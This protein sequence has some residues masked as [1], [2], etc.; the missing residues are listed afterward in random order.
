MNVIIMLVSTRNSTV[1]F[2]GIHANSTV[3][4]RKRDMLERHYS[5]QGT[6]TLFFCKIH[7]FDFL[8]SSEGI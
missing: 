7:L 3:S 5:I 1:I 8:P 6:F 2:Q 4:G